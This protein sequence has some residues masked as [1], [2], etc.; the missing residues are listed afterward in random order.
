VLHP[1]AVAPR[2]N[3]CMSPD[4]SDSSGNAAREVGSKAI[5]AVVGA[6]VGGVPGALLAVALEP[7]FIE[8]AARSWDELSELRRKSAGLMIETASHQLGGAPSD[9]TD[10]AFTT[11]GKAQ[12]FAE[13]LQAAAFTADQSKIKALGRALANGLAGDEARVDEERLIVA[14]LAGLEEPHIRVLL[15][16]PRQRPRPTSTPTSSARGS[17]GRRGARLSAVA[18]RAGLSSEGTINVMAELI[19]SGMA[20]Q[21]GY[22]SERRHDRLILELQTEI[23][24]LQ[25]IVENPGKKPSSNRRPKALK[26]PGAPIEAGFERTSFGD[27]C[28]E[29][30]EE[31]AVDDEYPDDAEVDDV[32]FDPY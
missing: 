1:L 29:Y 5:A 15:H 11:T 24:K 3:R 16:L 8:L 12:L 26:K 6:G 20:G 28:L 30:L 32:N 9:V 23:A 25:W 21:D 27:R 31:S 4:E 22:G 18:E 10:A 13:A 2:N 7:V 19:R 17:S 14:G